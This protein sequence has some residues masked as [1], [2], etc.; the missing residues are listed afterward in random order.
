[1]NRG[2]RSNLPLDPGDA[3]WRRIRAGL[4]LEGV[5]LAE[6]CKTHGVSR[7]FAYQCATGRRKGRTALQLLSRLAEAAELK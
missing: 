6:W 4:L 3:L 7:Q 1:M 2:L 5:T